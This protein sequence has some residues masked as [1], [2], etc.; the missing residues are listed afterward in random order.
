MILKR[1]KLVVCA[2]SL[3]LSLISVRGLNISHVKAAPA[4]IQGDLS[5]DGNNVTTI[6]GTFNIN[7]S[8]YVEDNATL[9]L[10]NAIVN[11]TQTS[12]Y[13][14]GMFFQNPAN[15]NPRL[16]S[17]NTTITSNLA[18]PI[19]FYE[20]SSADAFE[21]NSPIGD[22]EAIDS[23]SMLILNSTIK[24]LSCQDH[25]IVNVSNSEIILC[26]AMANSS[27][28]ISNCEIS[29]LKLYE[30]STVTISDSS[31]NTWLEIQSSSVNCSLVDLAKGF[32]SSWNYLLN[33]SVVI[34]AGG[35]ASNLTVKDTTISKWYFI[36]RG[37]SNATIYNSHLVYLGC[38]S[39]ATVDVMNSNIQ[40][41]YAHQSSNVNISNSTLNFINSYGTCRVN[42]LDIN[43]STLQSR[44]SSRLWLVNSTSDTYYVEDQSEVY[45]SWY[46][47]VNV[48]DSIDQNV[49]SANVTAYY[50]NATIAESKLTGVNG[51]TR[52]TLLE[53]MMNAT[54]DYPTGNYTVEA[55][56]DI[57][58]NET[59]VNMTGN[60]Q[61]TLTLESFIIPEFSSLIILPL[62]MTLTLLA[63]FLYNRKRFQ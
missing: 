13:R 58:S 54:G 41:V 40:G 15:G 51:W 57:Y 39:Y 25:S 21:L 26:E 37:S 29:S 14:Y 12:Q 23:S 10:R 5:L 47:D 59:T 4:I 56:Y 33:C 22:L 55:T 42:I 24:E 16:Q 19:L 32:T 28:S 63:A 8:I 36:F 3:L 18:F 17:E 62:F 6:E 11:F 7:G 45:V 35:F 60:Q 44:D 43:M 2:L 38:N 9:I 20:N 61:A 1:F 31:I 49:P 30:S 53:K 34:G 46:L 48:T 50:P 52:L 27:V